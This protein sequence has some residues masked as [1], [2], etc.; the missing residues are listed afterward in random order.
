V[1]TQV[2]NSSGTANKTPADFTINIDNP[3]AQSF[4]GSEAGKLLTLNVGNYSVEPVPDDSYAFYKSAECTGS[5]IAAQTKTCVVIYTAN[6]PPP[7]PIDMQQNI[8]INSWQEK[9]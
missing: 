1:V 3:S 2:N 6:P 4:P 9:T 5:I 8:D 7:P